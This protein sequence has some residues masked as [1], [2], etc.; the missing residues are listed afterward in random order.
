MG[1][2][3]F[4]SVLC[5]CVSLSLPHGGGV[6]AG[7]S[8]LAVEPQVGTSR[9]VDD[10]V[11]QQMVDAVSRTRIEDCVRRLQD[12][13]TR[14][15]LHDSS[16]AAAEYIR[17]ELLALGI[18]DV[19][20]H[21]FQVPFAPNIVAVIPGETVPDEFVIIGGHYD[22]TTGGINNDDCPGADDNGSGTAAVLECARILSSYEFDRSVIV[23]AFSAEE[24][25]LRG[26]A[27]WVQ[28]AVV[29]G[30]NITAAVILDMVADADL[31]FNLD[32][33]E[34]LLGHTLE[35]DIVAGYR[36]PRNDPWPRIVIA[37]LTPSD[38]ST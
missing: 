27:A 23:I 20:V 16:L 21:D 17:S 29:S 32:E 10:A 25:G 6:R 37:E 19:T 7:S 38:S 26:S 18:V 5:L 24:F 12:F 15:A 9:A 33:L 2:R 36:S 22:S 35:F 11:I 14:Y 31:Q 34:R 4:L 8:T 1:V 30:M 13:E 3:R 28:D